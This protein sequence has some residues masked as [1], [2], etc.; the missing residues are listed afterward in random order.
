M[1]MTPPHLSP[2]ATNAMVASAEVER[3]VRNFSVASTSPRGP[4]DVGGRGGAINGDLI[5]NDK[6]D[7]DK[8]RDTR[9][10][11][12]IAAPVFT[13]VAPTLGWSAPVSTTTVT[14]NRNRDKDRD[15]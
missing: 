1:T 14:N 9:G 12:R 11:T 10:S 13:G 15:R 4:G 6:D 5:R 3:T 2:T 8:D 7:K